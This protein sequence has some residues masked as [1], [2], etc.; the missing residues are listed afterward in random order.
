MSMIIELCALVHLLLILNDWLFIDLKQKMK[1]EEKW[2]LNNEKQVLE[3][4]LEKKTR[5]HEEKMVK[6]QVYR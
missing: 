3:T 1:D 5:E 2:L 4:E 6:D